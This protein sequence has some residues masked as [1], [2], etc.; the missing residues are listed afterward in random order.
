MLDDYL[1][2]NVSVKL[3]TGDVLP[4]NVRFYGTSPLNSEM[5]WFVI[6]RPSNP[7]ESEREYHIPV[8]SIVSM[9]FA[10]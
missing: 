8:T 5:L 4:A 7:I 3:V 10:K 9:E 1:N 2:K 6:P